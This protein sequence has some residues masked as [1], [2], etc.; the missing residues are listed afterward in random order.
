MN[1]ELRQSREEDYDFCYRITKENMYELFCRHWGGWD[2][3]EFDKGFRIEQI[4]LIILDGKRGGYVDYKTNGDSVY[5]YNI[6]ISKAYRG[7]GIG[8]SVLTS[9]LNANPGKR[10]I[11]TT[12]DD[13]P[14]MV[15]Y[16]RLGFKVS[17]ANHGTIRMERAAQQC[18]TPD[19][20]AICK[21]SR[22]FK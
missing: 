14:A 20:S 22:P 10:F 5:I 13:N 3:S 4:T 11:L 1:Y 6:Q 17:S 18:T 12:F 2:D 21:N 8:T 19:I 15:L 9:L 7:Q 16:K